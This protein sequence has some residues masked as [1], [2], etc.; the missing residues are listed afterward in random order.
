MVCDMCGVL[1]D[2][3]SVLVWMMGA[4]VLSGVVVY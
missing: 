3:V 4:I 2:D 1:G